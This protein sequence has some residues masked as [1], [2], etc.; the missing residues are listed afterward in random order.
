MGKMNDK[1]GRRTWEYLVGEIPEGY[2]IHHIDHNPKN[3]NLFNLACWPRENHNHYHHR[4]PKTRNKISVA[5]KASYINPTKAMIEGAKRGG[6]KNTGK[7]NK[8]SKG[9]ARRSE[10]NKDNRIHHFVHKDGEERICT[11]Y[12]FCK[13]FGFNTGS[14]V[15]GVVRGERKSHKGWKLKT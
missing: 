1:E 3:N 8:N 10:G 15:S 14:H 6:I 13:E 11:Q 12:D 7:T 5:V 9:I 4:S 2:D